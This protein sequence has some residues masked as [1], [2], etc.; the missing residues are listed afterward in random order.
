MDG[1]LALIGIAAGI[2]MLLIGYIWLLV[3]SKKFGAIWVFANLLVLPVIALFL[4]DWNKSWPALRSPLI[5][6]IIGFILVSM[7]TGMVN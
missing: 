4:I 1:L 5:V 6:A 3:A 2:P 7:T